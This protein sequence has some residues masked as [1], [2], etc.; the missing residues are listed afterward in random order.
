MKELALM[1]WPFNEWNRNALLGVA[2]KQAQEEARNG[3][4][5]SR[6]FEAFE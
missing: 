2:R 5:R 6:A 3:H 1:L 4:T